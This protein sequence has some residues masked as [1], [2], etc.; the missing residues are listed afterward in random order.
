MRAALAHRTE[1]NNRKFLKLCVVAPQN[2]CKIKEE[3]CTRKTYLHVII[4]FSHINSV[5]SRKQKGACLKNRRLLFVNLRLVWGLVL[6]RSAPLIW[7]LIVWSQ[8]CQ[9]QC[10]DIKRKLLGMVYGLKKKTNHVTKSN[11]WPTSAACDISRFPRDLILLNTFQWRQI[12]LAKIPREKV[13]S[14]SENASRNSNV[15]QSLAAFTCL[16]KSIQLCSLKHTVPRGCLE[17]KAHRPKVI[18]EQAS[19]IVGVH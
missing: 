8:E 6:F 4:F 10:N 9:I 14:V 12:S 5:S 19:M 2:W 1:R 7:L 15:P 11:C 13:F 16:E 17:I 18:V 3:T